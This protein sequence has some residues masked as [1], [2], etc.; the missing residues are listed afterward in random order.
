MRTWRVDLTQ[1][2][3]TTSAGTRE[4]T[5]SAELLSPS[6]SETHRAERCG[7]AKCEI[8]HGRRSKRRR[9]KFGMISSPVNFCDRAPLPRIDG[10][11][12]EHA[13][14]IT[15]ED[16]L[17]MY[18]KKNENRK[19]KVNDTSS[20]Q[21][22]RAAQSSPEVISCA[23]GGLQLHLAEFWWIRCS[24]ALSLLVATDDS[25]VTRR[26]RV[27]LPQSQGLPYLSKG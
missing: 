22:P 7:I 12:P 3:Y 2:R 1:R 11:K 5:A 21:S 18:C 14:K 16:R 19:Y 4:R 26:L 9:P 27:A 13:R 8:Q 15:K 23:P 10:L 6:R 17:G 25:R 20:G 24:V